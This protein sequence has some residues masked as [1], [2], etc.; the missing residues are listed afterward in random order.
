MSKCKQHKLGFKTRVAPRG[1]KGWAD[2]HRAGESAWLASDDDP[3]VDAR[4]AGR[5]LGYVRTWSV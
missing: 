2:D 3:L 5:G 1:A 4:P